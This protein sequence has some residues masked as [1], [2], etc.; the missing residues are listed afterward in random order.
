MEKG[1]A[2]ARKPPLPPRRQRVDE[3][4]SAAASKPPLP[5]RRQR[6]DEKASAAASKPP[7]PLRR[8]RVDDK[9]SKSPLPPR[10]RSNRPCLAHHIISHYLL[11]FSGRKS[12]DTSNRSW[13]A[14]QL[15]CEDNYIK[16]ISN[17]CVSMVKR[18]YNLPAD[19]PDDFSV[20]LTQYLITKVQTI[21]HDDHDQAALSL[22]KDGHCR[23]MFPLYRHLALFLLALCQVDGSLWPD[24]LAYHH[25]QYITM[26]LRSSIKQPDADD[27]S[28]SKKL[29]GS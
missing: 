3:K 6:I 19:L 14:D 26:K 10:Q 1:S 7:L 9:S 16:A 5:P 4:G 12:G 15:R 23:V 20:D 24:I 28:P 2:A 29:K 8:K 17:I 11:F 21:E 18:A 22:L 25:I 13:V 27:A